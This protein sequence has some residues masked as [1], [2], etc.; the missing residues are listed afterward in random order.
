MKLELSSILIYTIRPAFSG[1]HD[2]VGNPVE[3]T[4]PTGVVS[5]RTYDQRDRLTFEDDPVQGPITRTYDAN[6]N[7]ETLS[8]ALP[9]QTVALVYD[10]GS[11]CRADRKR[12]WSAHRPARL[13]G[14]RR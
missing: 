6:G 11:A 2:A 13:P 4:D 8:T 12:R 14:A 7:L 5:A 1:H 3:T 9:G 10:V